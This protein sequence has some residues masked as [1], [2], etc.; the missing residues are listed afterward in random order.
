MKIIATV[1]EIER[2][3]EGPPS[4]L[5]LLIK[6]TVGNSPHHSR[7][8]IGD[9]TPEQLAPYSVGQSVSLTI[10]PEA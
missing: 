7:L 10:E 4:V 8:V 3:G 1:T 6:S 5:V 2:A 9:L